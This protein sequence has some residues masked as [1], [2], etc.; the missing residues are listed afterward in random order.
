MSIKRRLMW[1]DQK[2]HVYFRC[3]FVCAACLPVS[4]I[5]HVLISEVHAQ[6]H[7]CLYFSMSLNFQRFLHFHPTVMSVAYF[8]SCFITIR[9]NVFPVPFLAES[10]QILVRPRVRFCCGTY[11]L[12]KQQTA[13]MRSTWSPMVTWKELMFSYR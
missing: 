9:K 3:F 2:Q 10:V 12:P 8:I 1:F 5:M 7:W 11:L 6:W 4:L 13:S